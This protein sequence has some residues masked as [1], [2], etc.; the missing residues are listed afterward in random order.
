MAISVDWAGTQVIYIPKSYL[1]LISGSV[2]SLDLNQFRL[3]LRDLED[4]PDGRL[5]P[6]THNHSTEVTL[7][8]IP[9]ARVIEILAPYTVEFEDGTYSV[10][11]TGANHNLGDVKVVNSVSLII[12]NS[13]GLVNPDPWT[14]VI[15]NNFTA[16]ELMRLIAS[17][18]LAKASGLDINTPVFR[19]LA[20][21]KNRISAVTDEHGNRI[22]VNLDAS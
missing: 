21:T 11:C 22:S 9:Y 15:E 13:A 19:D 10:S 17:A 7:S 14:K 12:N 1:T 2:Y 4:S 6:R 3:D 20:D 16:E 5:W 18:A 8:G